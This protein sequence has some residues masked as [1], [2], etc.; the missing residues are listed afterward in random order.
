[1]YEVEMYSIED[2]LLCIQGHPEYNRDILFD[3][4][5]RVLAGGY[6]K[7]DFAET[8]KAT[9]EKNEADR[10]IWQ[11]ICKNFLKGNP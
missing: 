3:I 8:S 2:N 6:I 5:D 10:K 1:M 4:I 9:M 11:K 7:Q